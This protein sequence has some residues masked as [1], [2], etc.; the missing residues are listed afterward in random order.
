MLDFKHLDALGRLEIGVTRQDGKLEVRVTDEGRGLSKDPWGHVFDPFFTTKDGGTAL[1]S[2][3]RAS[4][5]KVDVLMPELALERNDWNQTRR[6]AS[7][8]NAQ[9]VDLWHA[10]IR[11][12]SRKCI[13]S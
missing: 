6:E 1:G 2:P 11:V 5:F 7:G 4:S 12:E 3:S 8:A 9:G 10:E 13:E